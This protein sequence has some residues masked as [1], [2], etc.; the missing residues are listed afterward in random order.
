MYPNTIQLCQLMDCTDAQNKCEQCKFSSTCDYPWI[1]NL[2]KSQQTY[3]SPPIPI[4]IKAGI[5]EQKLFTLDKTEFLLAYYS[6][7]QDKMVVQDIAVSE[8]LKGQHRAEKLIY[9][10]LNYYD[11]DGKAKCMESNK[12]G[13]KFFTR[14]GKYVGQEILRTGTVMNIYI[15]HNPHKVKYKKELWY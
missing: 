14:I 10:A 15:I 7:K 1:L 4:I 9:E 6:K 2:W 8:Q 12:S 11:C 5:K 3:L 13:N